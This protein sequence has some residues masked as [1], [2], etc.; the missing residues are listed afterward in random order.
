M[1]IAFI[2]QGKVE[3]MRTA[4]KTKSHALGQNSLKFS[5]MMP[6]LKKKIEAKPR[7]IWSIRLY[8]LLLLTVFVNGPAQALE[9]PGPP[10]L[11][12]Y[13][14]IEWSIF[15]NPKEL[16]SWI[17]PVYRSIDQTKNPKHWVRAFTIYIS[18]VQEGRISWDEPDDYKKIGRELM[19]LAFQQKWY[20]DY[21]RLYRQFRE[22]DPGESDPAQS[23]E[24][25]L[26]LCRTLNGPAYLEINEQA[27]YAEYLD[28]I[29]KTEK[30]IQIIKTA[31]DRAQSDPKV[32]GLSRLI[33]SMRLA[34]LFSKSGD[35]ERSFALWDMAER[36]LRNTRLRMLTI[37]I[38]S[39]MGIQYYKQHTPEAY[40][41]A[42]NYF[43]RAL[44]AARAIDDKVQISRTLIA[45][46][47]LA[48]KKKNNQDGINF[49]DE[50]LRVVI[51]EP[52]WI[53]EALLQKARNQLEIGLF[54]EAYTSISEAQKHYDPNN[55]FDQR[56]VE[57][58]RADSLLGL[59]R[60]D[61][62][63][64]ALKRAYEIDSKMA[65]EQSKADLNS[66]LAELGVAVEKTRSEL[67]SKE[68]D[69]KEL[70]LKAAQ[71]FRLV[72]LT[73]LTLALLVM[74]LMVYSLHEKKLLAISQKRL[75]AILDHI[76][77]AIILIKPD[78]TIEAE[79][80]S[81]LASL[82][83]LPLGSLG[84]KHVSRD[85][86]SLFFKAVEDTT[87]ISNAL[88][89]CFMENQTAW[90]L[91]EG[92]LL[93]ATQKVID[94]KLH[95]YTFHWQPIFNSD[96]LLVRVLLGIRDAT[97][98]KLM[99]AQVAEE[100]QE[101]FLLFE[102]VQELIKVDQHQVAELL[103]RLT[104]MIKVPTEDIR[105]LRFDLHGLKGT[106]RSL[107]LKVLS[108]GIHQMEQQI[109]TVQ[110]IH[111]STLDW[112]GLSNIVA[113][114][115]QLLTEVLGS[116][117]G[118][119]R[120]ESGLAEV[121]AQLLPDLR[122]RAVESQLSWGGIELD[123]RVTRWDQPNFQSVYDLL[124]H[125]TSNSLDHG[126]REPKKRGQPLRP[127]HLSI[128]CFEHL[129]LFH[130]KITDSGSGIYWPALQRKAESLN[131]SWQTQE[132][133]I[134]LLFME[135]VS[136]ASQVSI[137]SGRGV[138]LSAMKHQLEACGGRL[139]IRSSADRGTEILCLWPRIAAP[140]AEEIAC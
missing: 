27:N 54:A 109:L 101:K 42:E 129:D 68:N 70:E 28:G 59:K 9:S 3:V 14:T 124:L 30:A 78:L 44:E 113:S 108:E 41:K 16:A 8:L 132:D 47:R 102:K 84:G 72:L 77:E 63:F 36:Q 23:F 12:D 104:N 100:R 61:E 90:D 71:R 46:S 15:D 87:L 56:Y 53:A 38:L 32:P 119:T 121:L 34:I 2:D 110:D 123:D 60:Y 22:P 98:R 29:G 131:F 6:I 21:L 139:E 80:S 114:Y 76:D 48:W 19:L 73:L 69:Q 11:D 133:L 37:N 20:E 81:F 7:S 79:Y 66:Q 75:R 137:T 65:A 25:Y 92:H 88:V 45:M 85:I 49:A 50:A 125:A 94:G 136:T 103:D 74:G 118:A 120:V 31:Y 67:L 140:T 116:L 64:I 117:G 52:D 5:L 106:S 138:G 122:Q 128:Q 58:V 33:L 26:D 82:L 93:Q 57:Q 86:L 105:R 95:F 89:A 17:K 18:Q 62:A 135:G 91:N 99:E 107:R 127:F 10:N 97:N 13:A 55:L 112:S 111:C 130:L 51:D 4:T 35:L 96:G 115:R 24:K 43:Q 39:N 40:E 134:P 1:S 83:E 126:Y